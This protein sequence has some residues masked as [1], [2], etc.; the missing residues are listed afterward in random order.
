MIQRLSEK[1]ILRP[2]DLQPSREDFA[3]VGV[4]NPGVVRVGYETLLLARVAG[5]TPGTSARLCRT[6]PIWVG[7]RIRSGLGAGRR[8]RS[9]G[10]Q[11]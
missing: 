8:P 10:C 6:S 5:A 7:Q 3:V 1:L 9:Y 4:F 2:Q 11:G